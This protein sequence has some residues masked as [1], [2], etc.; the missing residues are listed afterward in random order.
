MGAEGAKG[1]A[2]A[3]GVG[4]VSS[5]RLDR[6]GGC[7]MSSSEGGARGAPKAASRPL[8]PE[9]AAA[10]AEA[11]EFAA[12][13]D[14]GAVRAASVDGLVCL[15]D[16]ACSSSSTCLRFLNT[17]T[18]TK[19]KKETTTMQA[20]IR[21]SEQESR[22]QRLAEGVFRVLHARLTWTAEPQLIQRINPQHQSRQ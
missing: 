1:D 5:Q 7:K 20:T 10:A 15:V 3:D 8:P 14:A 9:G 19:R 6:G 4:R 13:E 22:E 17:P 16:T 11:A 12:A 18:K 21:A 2:G